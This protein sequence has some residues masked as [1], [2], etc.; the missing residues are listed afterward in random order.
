MHDGQAI[1][2]L[3]RVQ[4]RYVRSVHTAYLGPVCR[5]SCVEWFARPRPHQGYINFEVNCGGTLHCSY[6]EDPTRSADGFKRFT[7][8]PAALGAQVQ[9]YHSMP[10]VVDPE[11]EQPIVWTVEYRVPLSLFE[12]YVG[13]LGA[14]SGQVWAANFYKCGDDTSH[15]HWA[16]W[17]SVQELNFH[18]PQDFA[19]IHFE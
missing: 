7:F 18:R 12:H 1:Y 13:A 5:D 2:V 11:I 4:D 14:L 15:P 8:V 3:F 10:D 17:S 16:A 9:V 6:I 19:P